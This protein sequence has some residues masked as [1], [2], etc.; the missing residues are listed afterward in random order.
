[1]AII[2]VPLSQF[3]KEFSSQ[4]PGYRTMPGFGIMLNN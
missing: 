2:A 3:V 1:M 4:I